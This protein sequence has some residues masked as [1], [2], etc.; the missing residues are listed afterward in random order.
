MHLFIAHITQDQALL[1]PTESHHATRVMRLQAGDEI[2]VTS[3]D[4][5]MYRAVL[6]QM[7]Q[8][9]SIARILQQEDYQQKRNYHLTMA[10]SFTKNNDRMEWF[11]EK[12]TEIGIDAIQPVITHHSERRNINTERL[13]R[14]ILAAVKQSLKAEIPQVLQPIAFNQFVSEPLQATKLIAH[15]A[16]DYPRIPLQQ[17]ITPQ[18]SHIIL[19][20]PEGDFSPEEI[21]LAAQHQYQAISMGSQRMRTETAAL[22]AVMA[23]HQ[24]HKL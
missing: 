16:A 21:S 7:H 17:A 20:G 6:E 13:E 2:L 8:K 14:I 19:I 3:G 12:A 22:Y 15:C 4:G 11:A 10:V 9:R 1:N 18:A 24:A 23:M 5:K